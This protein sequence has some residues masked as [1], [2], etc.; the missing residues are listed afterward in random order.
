MP[1][2]GKPADGEDGQP[3]NVPKN[4]LPPVRIQAPFIQ[5][6]GG[7]AFSFCRLLGAE[8]LVLVT[9]QVGQVTVFL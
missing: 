3:T 7:G 6:K 4:H 1:S 2:I 8:I 9:V 5:E